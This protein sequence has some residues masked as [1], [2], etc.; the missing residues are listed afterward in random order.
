[1]IYRISIKRR[2]FSRRAWNGEMAGDPASRG[3]LHGSGKE[4]PPRSFAVELRTSP[5]HSRSGSR[6]TE[7]RRIRLNPQPISRR[8]R[9]DSRE[10]RGS[11][12]DNR[13]IPSMMIAVAP[14]TVQ[15]SALSWV[16]NPLTWASMSSEF[17][18]VVYWSRSSHVLDHLG[19]GEILP[20]LLQAVVGTEQ[21]TE[22]R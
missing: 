18:P 19:R 21:S 17:Q 22:H 16:L 8:P 4:N 5:R 13:A 10:H 7:A 9:A 14:N 6:K 20:E 15:N 11:T 2:N 3:G 12:S 1:M